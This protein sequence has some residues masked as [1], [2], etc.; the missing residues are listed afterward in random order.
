MAGA[1]ERSVFVASRIF[2]L[3]GLGGLSWQRL[4]SFIALISD[5]P[6]L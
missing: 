1:W 4:W 6:L 3:G 5:A 2:F